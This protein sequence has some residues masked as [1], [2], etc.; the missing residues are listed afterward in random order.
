MLLGRRRWRRDE[1]RAALFGARHLGGGTAS[2]DLRLFWHCFWKYMAQ[3]IWS[4]T[5]IYIY[6]HNIYIYI[7]IYTY[8][9]YI[10]YIRS[11]IIN[12]RRAIPDKRGEI[13]Q[14][15]WG[16]TTISYHLYLFMTFGYYHYYSLLSTIS[17][18]H[19]D[20]HWWHGAPSG[21]AETLRWLA[22]SAAPT[23]V[24]FALKSLAGRQLEAWWNVGWWQWMWQQG[25][26]NGILTD[27]FVYEEM[28]PPIKSWT[29]E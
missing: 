6:I 24:G 26:D 15:K 20:Y 27:D 13:H 12:I 18:Y 4:Y 7:Y 21:E 1:F 9:W 23:D 5:Y 2:R 10:W 17:Y 25:I 22:R 14:T 19:F 8:I 3:Y 16:G 29:S 11:Y 28:D